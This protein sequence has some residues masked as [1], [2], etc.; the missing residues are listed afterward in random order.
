VESLHLLAVDEMPWQFSAAVGGLLALFFGST[1]LAEHVTLQK[2]RPQEDLVLPG[3]F[4]AW[5]SGT[6]LSEEKRPEWKSAFANMRRFIKQ[7]EKGVLYFGFSSPIKK[8]DYLDFILYS[9][10]VKNYGLEVYI[11]SLNIETNENH[12]D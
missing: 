11:R 2:Q 6:A 9:D 4:E 3:Q 10:P 1:W 7:N 8:G 5:T 12:G